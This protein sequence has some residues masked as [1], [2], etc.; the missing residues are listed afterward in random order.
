[1]LYASFQLK[2]ETGKTNTNYNISQSQLPCG[3]KPVQMMGE[4]LGLLNLEKP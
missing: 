3:K 4:F 1:M 2:H